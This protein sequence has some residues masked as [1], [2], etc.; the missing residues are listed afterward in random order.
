MA[1]KYKEHHERNQPK[2]RGAGKHEKSLQKV[3]KDKE[4]IED[5]KA[6]AKA[7]QISLKVLY[8]S[9]GNKKNTSESSRNC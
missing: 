5:I 7:R 4:V 8:K 2:K 9:Y 1:K 6:K 3:K